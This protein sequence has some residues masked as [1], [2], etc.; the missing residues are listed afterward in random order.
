MGG[1]RCGKKVIDNY[2]ALGGEAAALTTSGW[3]AFVIEEA[4]ALLVAC[5][6]LSQAYEYIDEDI[7]D[8]SALVQTVL[9]ET[10]EAC[11]W[12]KQLRVIRDAFRTI[13][14][15]PTTQDMPEM[16]RD[17]DYRALGMLMRGWRDEMND[18]Y[19]KIAENEL[20]IQGY[21]VPAS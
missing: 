14:S 21:E 4:T 10:F 16:V 11:A 3:D 1:V 17:R 19:R 9:D 6:A 15:G 13:R 18:F 12:A 5:Q 2:S 7:K 20:R 8:D